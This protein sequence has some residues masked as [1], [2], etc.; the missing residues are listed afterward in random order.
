MTATPIPRTMTMTLF[1]DLDVSTLRDSPPG[2]QKVNTYLVREAERARWWAFFAKKLREGRQGFVVAPLV[3]ES[4]M[5]EAA[6]IQSTYESLAN[7]PLEAFRLGL[8]HGRMTSDEKDAVMSDFR[9]GQIQTLVS[10][11]VVEVGVDVPNATLMA[12]EAGERFGLAQL[13]QLR[14]RISRGTY[15]GFCGVFADPQTEEAS[16]RLTAF[17]S[18]TDGFRLAEIDFELR[19]PG[20]LLGS[21]QHGLP[22]FRVAD[23]TRDAE[24]LE[25]TR[26]DARALVAADPELTQAEHAGLRRQVL[27]RYGQA[28]DLADVG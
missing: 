24:T 21:R 9:S 10:T 8:I 23:L 6:S 19:G 5:I 7:G 15:A 26:R 13:H 4:E 18:T 3:E 22:P 20:E 28:L 2:R 11:S 25:E 14:G 27:T 17:A 12:I 16:K 1:G